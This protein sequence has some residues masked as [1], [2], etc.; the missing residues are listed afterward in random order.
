MLVFA[1]DRAFLDELQFL[2]EA[3]DIGVLHLA[4]RGLDIGRR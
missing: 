4:E 1:A 3:V 2:A